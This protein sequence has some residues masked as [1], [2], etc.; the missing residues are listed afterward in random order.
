MRHATLFNLFFGF[1]PVHVD[2][3]SEQLRLEALYRRF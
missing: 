3:G 1:F 2:A